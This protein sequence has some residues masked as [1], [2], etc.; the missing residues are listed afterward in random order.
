MES[1][2]YFGVVNN[3]HSVCSG[4]NCFKI[5]TPE[6]RRAYMTDHAPRS[7]YICDEAVAHEFISR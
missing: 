7:M 3:L 5:G 6:S 1:S 2:D 4:S